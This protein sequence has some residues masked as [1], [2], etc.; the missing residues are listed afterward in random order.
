MSPQPAGRNVRLAIIS[1]ALLAAC[2][3][4][5][6]ARKTVTNSASA[7]GL[8]GARIGNL[9][10]PGT[11]KGEQTV[12]IEVVAKLGAHR[13]AMA[14]VPV[15]IDERGPFLF[16]LDTGASSSLVS[17]TLA[18]R[19]RLPAAGP[20]EP[21]AGIGGAG[22]AYPVRIENWTAGKVALPPSEI[23]AMLPSQERAK[24]GVGKGGRDAGRKG[25]PAVGLLGSDVLSRYGKIAVDYN[26][27][28]LILDPRVP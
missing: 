25:G 26:R 3:S 14:L 2:V 18:Q 23:D 13:A 20:V 12:Q 27:G 10:T 7:V 21:I 6:G 1:V 24:G 19:L 17:S 15:Y 11:P 22:R 8:N 5:G 9:S 4:C 28:L 16:A